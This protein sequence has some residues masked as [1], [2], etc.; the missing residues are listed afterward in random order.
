MYQK[1]IKRLL[2]IIFSAVALIVLSPVM[3][4][5]ALV[6]R[7]KLGSPVLFK[8]QRPGKN[9][10]IFTL[11]KFRSMKNTSVNGKLLSDEERLTR[12]GR[13]LRSTS[14]DGKVIIRPNHENSVNTRASQVSP[15]HFFTGCNYNFNNKVYGFLIKEK[16]IA[17]AIKEKLDVTSALVA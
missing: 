2:D 5:T 10:E 15:N 7:V 14:L 8:Q 12:F 4:C 13:I 3:L 16:G 11:Y 17:E 9:G 1:Y 6:V